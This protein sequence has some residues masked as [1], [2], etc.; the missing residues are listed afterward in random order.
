M[1]HWK[2]QLIYKCDNCGNCWE[3]RVPHGAEI[4][5]H[6]VET[7]RAT[8]CRECEWEC[9]GLTNEEANI[10]WAIVDNEETN[11]DGWVTE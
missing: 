3:L 11:L 4:G 2:I 9:V 1:S 8:E 7:L 6:T 10:W 5:D